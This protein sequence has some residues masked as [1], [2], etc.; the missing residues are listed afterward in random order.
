MSDR[1][2]AGMRGIPPIVLDRPRKVAAGRSPLWPST[3]PGPLTRR[4][5]TEL[6]AQQVL[7]ALAEHDVKH[8]VETGELPGVDDLPRG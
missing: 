6:L 3:A 7:D 5:E 8:L 2:G 4:V 1:A